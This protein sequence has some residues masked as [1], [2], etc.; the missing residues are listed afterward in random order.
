MRGA[1]VGCELSQPADGL[2][3]GPSIPEVWSDSIGLIREHRLRVCRV[4]AATALVV[5]VVAC[6]S[7]PVSKGTVESLML[8]KSSNLEHWDDAS[9]R[10]LSVATALLIADHAV[11]VR[12]RAGGMYLKKRTAA[13][14]AVPVSSDGYYV[15]ANHCLSSTLPLAVV[16]RVDPGGSWKVLK[17]HPRTVWRAGPDTDVDL[18]LFQLDFKPPVVLPLADVGTL[19]V[20]QRI[21][22][23]GWSVLVARNGSE[24]LRKASADLGWVWDGRILSVARAR[25][26]PTGSTFRIVRHDT[27]L[28]PGDSGGPMI[29][30]AGRLIGINVGGS[31]NIPV[32]GNPVRMRAASYAGAKAVALDAEW[33]RATI[34]R[35]R[36][37]NAAGSRDF[38]TR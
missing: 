35:D 34:E 20:R 24:R 4:A 19:R 36:V 21:A 10:R 18:A 6:Q 12:K 23:A 8:A 9:V 32:N 13:C 2:Y 37:R 3:S 17:K 5:A 22:S 38:P 15:T 33:L 11:I 31:F 16:V 25:N 28:A 29:D 1:G 27:A 26:S 14:S 30:A 7:G